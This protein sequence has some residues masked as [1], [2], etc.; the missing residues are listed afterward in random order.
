MEHGFGQTS[1]QV[2]FWYQISRFRWPCHLH[3]PV[4]SSSSSSLLFVGAATIRSTKAGWYDYLNI[5]Y[6]VNVIYKLYLSK[7]NSQNLPSLQNFQK[8]GMS[9]KRSKTYID[10]L[11]HRHLRLTLGVSCTRQAPI[12]ESTWSTPPVSPK[13]SSPSPK[14]SRPFLARPE[15]PGFWCR[16]LEV[17]VPP[18]FLLVEK[19]LI[20]G[21][22]SDVWRKNGLE[23]EEVWWRSD[24]FVV[25]V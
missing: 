13:V 6:T 11:H 20:W 12:D 22:G 14:N 7:K 15:L 10:F 19:K 25:G 5:P 8:Q 17:T 9:K 23:T 16:L 24:E 4:C 3:T 18:V 1:S 2:H 21:V